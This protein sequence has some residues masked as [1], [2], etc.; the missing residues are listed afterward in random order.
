MKGAQTAPWVNAP[1]FS[2]L[3]DIVK[4]A[5]YSPSMLHVFSVRDALPAASVDKYVSHLYSVLV[6]PMLEAFV[7]HCSVAYTRGVW[8]RVSTRSSLGEGKTWG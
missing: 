4:V 3:R 8:P 1:R 5:R 7:R 2:N 6:S